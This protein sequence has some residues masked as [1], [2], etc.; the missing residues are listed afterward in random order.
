MSSLLAAQLFCCGPELSKAKGQESLTG[1]ALVRLSV[2][3]QSNSFAGEALSFTKSSQD[4]AG[5]L[6]NPIRSSERQQKMEEVSMNFR[7]HVAISLCAYLLM[8]GLLVAGLPSNVDAATATI[9]L[10]QIN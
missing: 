8:I 1:N 6:F 10:S 7:K 9:N 2:R 5:T 4:R 3:S